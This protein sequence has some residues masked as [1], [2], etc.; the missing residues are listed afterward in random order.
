MT[1]GP[2]MARAQAEACVLAGVGISREMPAGEGAEVVGTGDMGIGNTTAAS[3][4][5][6]AL[7]EQAALG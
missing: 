7:T 5:T 6:A 2:A 4:I 3:A 1:Q